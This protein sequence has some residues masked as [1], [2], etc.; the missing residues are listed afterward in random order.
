MVIS[1]M[2]NVMEEITLFSCAAVAYF[3][4]INVGTISFDYLE[5]C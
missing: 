5:F 2:L 4:W 3:H 1:V